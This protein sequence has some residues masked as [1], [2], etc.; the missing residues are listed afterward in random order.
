[1]VQSECWPWRLTSVNSEVHDANMMTTSL[2]ATPL[3]DGRY[4]WSQAFTFNSEGC[5]NFSLPSSRHHASIAFPDH[6]ES[7][8]LTADA[9]VPSNRDLIKKCSMHPNICYKCV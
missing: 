5:S 1:M 3:R 4:S 7:E 8:P 9:S 2:I 6:H